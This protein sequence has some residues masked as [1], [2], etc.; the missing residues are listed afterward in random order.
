MAGG[1]ICDGH[2]DW[3]V[4]FQRKIKAASSSSTMV[5][6]WALSDGL[7][8]ALERNLQGVLVEIDSTALARL[9]DE[10]ELDTHEFSNILNDCRFLIDLKEEFNMCFG[11]QNRSTNAVVKLPCSSNTY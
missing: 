2:G 1:L 6:C 8:L 3:F 9:L 5:Q 10:K 7:K 11:K 4:G